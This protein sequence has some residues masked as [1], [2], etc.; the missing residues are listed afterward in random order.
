MKK[1][2]I[3]DNIEKA[4]Q[5]GVITMKE[6]RFIN[7]LAIKFFQGKEITDN[8]RRQRRLIKN[9]ISLFIYGF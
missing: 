6:L 4:L 1:V 7:D 9:K 8:E 5:N 2:F 3:G